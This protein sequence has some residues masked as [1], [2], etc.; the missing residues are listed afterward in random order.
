MYCLQDWHNQTLYRTSK[1]ELALI[2]LDMTLFYRL[3]Y[4]SET[5][6]SDHSP[7]YLC[8]EEVVRKSILF[9]GDL[10]SVWFVRDEN[11]FVPANQYL[12]FIQIFDCRVKDSFINYTLA[13]T[14][15]FNKMLLI[16]ACQNMT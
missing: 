8:F 2:L 7:F 4:I 15:N 16:V 10:N 6:V 14:N 11:V 5:S 9:H 1:I 12:L 3:N 13:R